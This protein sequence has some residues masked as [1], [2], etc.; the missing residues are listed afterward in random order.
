MTSLY[1]IGFIHLYNT[2]VSFLSVYFHP[3]NQ[4]LIILNFSKLKYWIPVN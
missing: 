1:N 3:L 2:L 4:V